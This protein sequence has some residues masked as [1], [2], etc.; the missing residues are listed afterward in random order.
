MSEAVKKLMK[1]RHLHTD[2]DCNMGLQP[3]HSLVT[4]ADRQEESQD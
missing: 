3:Y 1:D 2:S 4:H